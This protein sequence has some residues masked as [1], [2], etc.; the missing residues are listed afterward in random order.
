MRN[1]ENGVIVVRRLPEES[2][3]PVFVFKELSTYCCRDVENQG[4]NHWSVF[5]I[6][7]LEFIPLC[8]TLHLFTKDFINYYAITHAVGVLGYFKVA[9]TGRE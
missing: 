5:A 1:C 7:L 6:F 4:K 2:P 9:S 8:E 3:A